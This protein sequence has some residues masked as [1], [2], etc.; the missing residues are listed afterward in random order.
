MAENDEI[1]TNES[2]NL[3]PSGARH[4]IRYPPD[5]HQLRNG[6]VSDQPNARSTDGDVSGQQDERWTHLATSTSEDFSMLS[7]DYLSLQNEPRSGH[8]IAV[9]GDNKENELRVFTITSSDTASSSYP[10][11]APGN[12]IQQA[13][14]V[15]EFVN[16]R[17][18]TPDQDSSPHESLEQGNSTSVGTSEST[19]LKQYEYKRVEY[20]K[21]PEKVR[22]G[23]RLQTFKDL[24]WPHFFPSGEVLAEADLFYQGVFIDEYDRL[25][26]DQVVCYKCGGTLREW[27]SNDHPIKEHRKCFPLCCTTKWLEDM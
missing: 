12:V 21:F 22:Y 20:S 15:Q 11:L 1:T 2:R 4:A 27:G 8:Y 23:D 25:I 26:K 13:N 24:D 3:L 18:H 17:P 9:S 14:I 19:Y 5:I 10:P 6:N 16:S 7:S